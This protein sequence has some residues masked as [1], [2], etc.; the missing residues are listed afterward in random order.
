MIP[1]FVPSKGRAHKLREYMPWI[2]EYPESKFLVVDEKEQYEYSCL[3]LPLLTHANLSGNMSKI[4]NFI[5]TIAEAKWARQW[6]AMFDDDVAK[7]EFREDVTAKKEQ[8]NDDALY[9]QHDSGTS[10]AQ[11]LNLLSSRFN[12]GFLI[13]AN[14][15]GNRFL[16]ASGPRNHAFVCSD[17][18]LIKLDGSRY[19][20]NLPVKEDYYMTA[21][22]ISEGKQIWSL[23]NLTV[24]SRHYNK[25]GCQSLDVAREKLDAD[26]KTYLLEKFPAIFKPNNAWENKKN[27]LRFIRRKHV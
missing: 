22:M 2:W 20:E 25:G 7:L 21:K 17:A 8:L 27:E 16:K 14:G 26:A 9:T 12:D 13:G 23:G 24:H 19:D 10:I 5:L 4:R 15:V 1:L 11:L 18:F 6:I 3:D